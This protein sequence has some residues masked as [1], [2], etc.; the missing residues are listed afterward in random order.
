MFSLGASPYIQDHMG[1]NMYTA[2]KQNQ[3]WTRKYKTKEGLERKR[4]MQYIPGSEDLDNL[5]SIINKYKNRW[6]PQTHLGFTRQ[7]RSQV[8]TILLVNNRMSHLK[9]PRYITTMI[10]QYLAAIQDNVENVMDFLKTHIIDAY[11]KSYPQN[12][13]RYYFNKFGYETKRISSRSEA[14]QILVGNAYQNMSKEYIDEL[15][16]NIEEYIVKHKDT[17][18]E[19]LKN[20]IFRRGAREIWDEKIAMHAAI[21]KYIPM[22]VLKKYIN[23]RNRTPLKRR[24]F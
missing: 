12:D 20:R 13:Y 1:I 23:F 5:L 16:H 19:T 18:I 7:F 4:I 10:F 24:K 6:S 3:W 8:K 2:V 9:L 21:M 22:Q 17:S 11:A 14:A 15:T